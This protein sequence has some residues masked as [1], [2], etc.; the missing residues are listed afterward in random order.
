M[1]PA[2]LILSTVYA[3]QFHRKISDNDLLLN[4]SIDGTK[5]AL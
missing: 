4:A 2:K 3:T 5:V 1:T